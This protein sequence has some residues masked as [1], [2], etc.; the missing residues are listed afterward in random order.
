MARLGFSARSRAALAVSGGS[1]S[2][3]LMRFFLAW[4]DNARGSKP[5][6]LT[7][8]HG[9]RPE[10]AAD[11]HFVIAEAAKLGLTAHILDWQGAKPAANLED[12]AREARYRLMGEWCRMH[13]VQAVFVAHTEDDQAETFLLR[14]G[15]GSGVDGLS[16]MR[17]RGP[18]PLPGFSLELF[19]P[20]L[21]MSRADLRSYLADNGVKWLE[22]PMN[23]DPRFARPRLRKLLPQLAEAGVTSKRIADAAAHLAR[24][25]EALDWEVAAFLERHSR[26]ESAGHVLV[27][28]AAL[29]QVPREIGLRALATLLLRVSGGRYRPRFERLESLFHAVTGRDFRQARTLLGCR[30]GRAAKAQAQF[31]PETL[32]LSRES[33]RRPTRPREAPVKLKVAVEQPNLPKKGRNMAVSCNS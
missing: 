1:D 3:A 11:A 7:V 30:I 24:A 13:D 19:R 12:A 26:S 5:V 28:R 6:V 10:S 32:V 16:A 33:D 14:L 4:A 22:D 20:L 21:G 2:L 23:D 31:G 29:A 17:S 25:R 8:D 15:R 9:L 27:D 18:Y